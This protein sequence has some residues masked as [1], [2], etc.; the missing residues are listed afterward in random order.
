[1]KKTALAFVVLSCAALLAATSPYFS[2]DITADTV[3]I[4]SLNKVE[5]GS[6]RLVV[7]GADA[8]NANDAG[9]R[10]SSDYLADPDVEDDSRNFVDAWDDDGNLQFP[11]RQVDGAN[12]TIG[13]SST[14]EALSD[15][16]SIEFDLSG[17]V[18]DTAAVVSQVVARPL[19]DVT[20]N[21]YLLSFDHL[22][23]TG[24]QFEFAIIHHDLQADDSVTLE[25]YTGS[26]WTATET[27]IS[28]ANST[29]EA[30]TQQEF[31]A[32][33]LTVAASIPTYEVRFRTLAV[34]SSGNNYLDKVILVESA[35]DTDTFVSTV[36]SVFRVMGPGRVVVRADS[37]TV[38]NI[39]GLEE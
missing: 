25:Y 11:W 15:D 3:S 29:T 13:K 35:L 24:A 34:G 6:V 20:A 17:A 7:Q 22:D 21:S 14:T 31:E 28:V 32:N 38:I 30:R 39:S 23:G 26:A 10:I 4:P 5:G 1:M 33:T 2:E 16:A 18:E 27:W 36:P 19:T 8:E 9:F 37:A 12:I